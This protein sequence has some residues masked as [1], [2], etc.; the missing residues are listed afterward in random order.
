MDKAAQILGRANIEFD[1]ELILYQAK[2]NGH[3][4]I[5]V[6][7]DVVSYNKWWQSST[8]I[9]KCH[10]EDLIVEHFVPY[11]NDHDPAKQLATELY[12]QIKQIRSN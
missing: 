2:P 4:F 9:Q 6:F 8:Y 7:P 1:G 10:T 11:D 12:A 3:L 5:L